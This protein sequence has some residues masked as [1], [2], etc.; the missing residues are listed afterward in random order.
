MAL[1][2]N[3]Y[4]K[5]DHWKMKP[6]P[7]SSEIKRMHVTKSALEADHAK[8]DNIL[9]FYTVFDEYLHLP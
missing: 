8:I 7:K 1:C 4:R 2:R 5:L 6:I 3:K 9:K